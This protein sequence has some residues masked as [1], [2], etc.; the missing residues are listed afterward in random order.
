MKKTPLITAAIFLAVHFFAQT[1]GDNQINIEK[2]LPASNPF[3]KASELSYQAP[4]FDK[5]KDEDYK[6]ALEEGIKQQLLEINKIA[7]STEPPTF[8]NT[9]EAM[10]KTG[11]LLTRVNNIFSLMTGANTND[12]LQQLREEIAPQLAAVQDAIYLNSKLFKRIETVY[13]DREK[14]NLDTESKR[15]VEWDYEEF[16]LAGAKLSDA[17]KTRMKE[18]NKE[19]ATLSARFTNQLLKAAKAGTVLITD[20]TELAGLSQTDKDAYAQNAKAK[21]LSGWLIPLQNTTQ[22]PALQSLKNRATR[23]KLFEASWNRAEKN[24]SNDTRSTI[25]RLA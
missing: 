5:I 12:T 16:F 17:E 19:E 25:L 4:Q 2:T 7:G 18:L 23:Q 6:P 10:E 9:I 11:Q 8:E 21:N 13:N 24:D 15:L 20:S 3:A 22:Q 14:L 1:N